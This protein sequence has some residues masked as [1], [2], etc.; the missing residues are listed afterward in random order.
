VL[1]RHP[2]IAPVAPRTPWYDLTLKPFCFLLRFQEV[3]FFH[4]LFRVLFA[5]LLPV[6]WAVLAERGKALLVPHL[7]LALCTAPIIGVGDEDSLM[8]RDAFWRIVEEIEKNAKL[9]D[10]CIV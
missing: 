4:Y 6:A 8:N 10:P 5:D 9:Y 7:T 1:R 2:P 3:V